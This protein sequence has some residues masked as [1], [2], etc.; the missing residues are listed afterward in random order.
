V[1]TCR[2]ERALR[3]L[4]LNAAMH[5]RRSDN[6]RK[7]NPPSA[8][9]I[10]GSACATVI[11]LILKFRDRR[12]TDAALLIDAARTRVARTLSRNFWQQKNFRDHR[13]CVSSPLAKT[14]FLRESPRLIRHRVLAARSNRWPRSAINT[15]LQARDSE[16]PP[17]TMTASAVAAFRCRVWI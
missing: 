10:A 13:L 7:S 8:I 2:R 11:S 5:A 3:A 1:L 6:A 14:G 4:I 15:R 9:D 16:P 17:A 12:A